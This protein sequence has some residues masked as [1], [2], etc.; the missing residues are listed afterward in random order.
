MY[1]FQKHTYRDTSDELHRLLY[2]YPEAAPSPQ[3]VPSAPS[4]AQVLPT[5]ARLEALRREFPNRDAIP[6]NPDHTGHL[7]TTLSLT[8]IENHI[9]ID[10]LKNLDNLEKAIPLLIA[11]LPQSKGRDALIAG[12]QIRLAYD[13]D[14]A[15]APNPDSPDY[16]LSEEAMK[17]LIFLQKLFTE[18]RKI[19]ANMKNERENLKES[20]N[21]IADISKGIEKG[22]DNFTRMPPMQ[23]CLVGGLTAFAAWRLWSST[24]GAGAKSSNTEGTEGSFLFGLASAVGIYGA[25]NYLPSMVTDSRKS[26]WDRITDLRATDEGSLSAKVDMPSFSELLGASGLQGAWKEEAAVL[27]DVDMQSALDLLHDY[28]KGSPLPD[29]RTVRNKL[30][31]PRKYAGWNAEKLM[32]LLQHVVEQMPL[33]IEDD[34][35]PNEKRTLKE[36][37]NEDLMR[38]WYTTPGGKNARLGQVMADY[39][40]RTPPPHR[41]PNLT[42]APFTPEHTEAPRDIN[43]VHITTIIIQNNNLPEEKNPEVK[44][45]LRGNMNLRDGDKNIIELLEKGDQLTLELD[46]AGNR[47]KQERKIGEKYYDCYHV[48]AVNGQPKDGW[49][50]QTPRLPR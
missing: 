32:G 47:V 23:Q 13:R 44:V 17:T 18:R 42:S 24:F 16:V 28:P 40:Y 41:I 36:G 37:R 26:T 2:R 43:I 21:T 39:L 11:H 4:V 3:A 6:A 10:D 45:S 50:A 9:S 35:T 48:T 7:A 15:H 20:N 25:V 33:R 30:N 1:I 8:E 5:D 34:L 19:M 12:L 31:I 14:L 29:I 49:I 38:Q 22:W 27:L 46:R